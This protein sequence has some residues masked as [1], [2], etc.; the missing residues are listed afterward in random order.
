M[1]VLLVVLAIIAFFIL[2]VAVIGLTLKLLWWALIGLAIGA[3]SRL[4][5]PGRQPI[6][7]LGTAG[8]G[9]AGALLG[10]IIAHALDLS[11]VVQ[12]LIAVAVA[13]GLILVFS[14]TRVGERVSS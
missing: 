13:A 4:V 14:G 7:L 10:G 12:F 9:I 2:G 1:I 11:G 3:L 5:L 8:A 6:S